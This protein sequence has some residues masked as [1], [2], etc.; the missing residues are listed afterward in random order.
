[1]V[2]IGLRSIILFSSRIKLVDQMRD[3]TWPELQEHFQIFS[4]TFMLI[5][6]LRSRRFFMQ[7]VQHQRLRNV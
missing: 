6:Q 5:D 7:S 2:A 3:P 4:T 1:M